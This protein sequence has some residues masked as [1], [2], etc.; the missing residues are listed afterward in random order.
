MISKI[1]CWYL[2]LIM[3]KNS[4]GP[5]LQGNILLTTR[6]LL[7]HIDGVID[8]WHVALNGSYMYL[9]SS[10]LLCQINLYIEG[11]TL[12]PLVCQT[13]MGP[14]SHN[15]VHCLSDLFHVLPVNIYF[16]I[17]TDRLVSRFCTCHLHACKG[18]F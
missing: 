14:S 9:W 17:G 2:N 1:S 3:Q 6:D 5:I 18:Q 4:E 8:T 15:G 12:C 7:M 13:H 10:A 16:K 11:R